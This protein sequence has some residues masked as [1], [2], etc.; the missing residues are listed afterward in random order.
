VV[1]IDLAAVDLPVV[2][3][4]RVAVD[5]LLVALDSS[6]VV[7]LHHRKEDD[8]VENQVADLLLLWVD[9]CCCC[10][11][12]EMADLHHHLLVAVAHPV[13]VE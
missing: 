8:F 2:V 6:W 7:D 9:S 11:S 1:D 13:G 10:C 12:G 4:Q 5:H 3:H